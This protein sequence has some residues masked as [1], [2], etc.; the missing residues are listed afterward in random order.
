MRTALVH[1]GAGI[2]NIVLATPLIS[3][4][5]QIDVTVDLCLSADYPETATLF[6]GW[7]AIRQVVSDKHLPAALADR[8]DFVIAAIPPF[9]WMRFSRLLQGHP[10][11]PDRLFYSDEQGWYLAFATDLGWRGSPRPATWLPIAPSTDRVTASSVVLAPGSKTGEM[12]RK[13]WPHFAGLADRLSDLDV[14]V[15]G[16]ADDLVTGGEQVKFPAH[17]RNYT[18]MLTLR[19]TAA[20]IGGAGAAVAND[21]GLAHVAAAVGTPTITLFGPTSEL[22]LG[23]LALHQA[24]LRAPF[25]CAPCWQV[26]RFAACDGRIDCLR[27]LDAQTVEREVRALIGPVRGDIS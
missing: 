6:E 18:G 13:R 16:T 7:P 19:E 9:Y 25:E 8:H 20:L 22:V 26:A 24:T 12:A 21:N 3:A 14:V 1:L 5:E 11:P 23:Q 15:V 4:L 2:G 27:S 17:V 10:R